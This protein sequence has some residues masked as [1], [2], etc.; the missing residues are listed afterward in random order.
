[1]KN[2]DPYEP[3]VINW[4]ITRE[5][6]RQ[7]LR[8]KNMYWYRMREMQTANR[9]FIEC[10]TNSIE[11]YKKN[12]QKELVKLGKSILKYYKKCQK[13]HKLDV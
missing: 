7:I 2:K 1:M 6:Y 4:P 9:Q 12:N 10:L 3:L 13:E 5:R 8:K 11:F